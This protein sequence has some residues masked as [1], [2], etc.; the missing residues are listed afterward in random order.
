MLKIYVFHM[1]TQF[2]MIGESVGNGS[3]AIRT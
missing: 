3:A 2:K 1:N